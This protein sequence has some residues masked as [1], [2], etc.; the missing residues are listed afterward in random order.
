VSDVR[1]NKPAFWWVNDFGGEV[2]WNFQELSDKSK[3]CFGDRGIFILGL[4]YVDRAID[5]CWIPYTFVDE[6]HVLQDA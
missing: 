2:Q 1:Q 4:F 5:P 3:R 6:L